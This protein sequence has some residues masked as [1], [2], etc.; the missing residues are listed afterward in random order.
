MSGIRLE[1]KNRAGSCDG[2]VIG[3]PHGCGDPWETAGREHSSSF[4]CISDLTVSY[5]EVIALSS[6]SIDI[7]RGSVT[8]VIGPSGCGKSSFLCCLNRLTLFPVAVY[9]G[10]SSW[11]ARTFWK[12]A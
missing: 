8:A 11:V 2:G 7:T 6:V 1:G 10:G 5:G 9:R 3:D 4:W 12:T